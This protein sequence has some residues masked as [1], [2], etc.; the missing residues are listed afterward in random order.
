MDR[1][2]EGMR[3]LREPG[4]GDLVW[5]EECVYSF[6]T[7]ADAGGLY[8]NL[9]TF[10]AVSGEYAAWEFARA[11]REGRVGLYLLQQW[12]TTTKEEPAAASGEAESGG[13]AAAEGG[14]KLTK[15]GIGVEGGAPLA[16][17]PE[18]SK[19]HFVV[20]WDGSGRIE[21]A[22]RVALEDGDLPEMVRRVCEAVLAHDDAARTAHVQSA[23]AWEFQ[24]KESKYAKALPLAED[25]QAAPTDPSAWKCALCELTTP[26]WLNLSTGVVAC[27]RRQPDGSGGRGHALEHFVA[28]GRRYPLCVKLGTIT[29]E[30]GGDVYSYAPDEDDSVLD[31]YLREHLL[32]LGLD[33]AS[34]RK[35]EKT[36]MELTLDA[37][38]KLVLDS[39]TEE[40][41]E[42]VP[43]VARGCVGLVN[44]GNSCYMNSVLQVLLS[45]PEVRA[46]YL[47]PRAL[48]ALQALDPRRIPEDLN[49]QVCKLALAL[50]TDQ[51][52]PAW[53]RGRA[54]LVLDPP[55]D[56]GQEWDRIAVT[57]RVVRTV[58][59][60]GHGEFMT[61]R[62]QDTAE[63]LV[64]VLDRLAAVERGAAADAPADAPATASLFRF[65][66]ETRIQCLESGK[67]RYSDAAA[68]PIWT[69]AIPVEL[70]SNPAEVAES[71]ARQAAWDEERKAAVLAAAHVAG[72]A[73]AEKRARLDAAALTKPPKAVLPQVSWDSVLSTWCDG[74]LI[75]DLFSTA[76]GRNGP[77]QATSRFANFP[78]YLCVQLMRQVLDAS[79]KEVKID[80]M[81][82]MPR[83]LDLEALRAPGGLQPGEELLAE[84]P[85]AA[86]AG[87]RGARGAAPAAFTPDADMLVMLQGMGFSENACK[88][89]LRAVQ[90][91]GLE[92]ASDWLMGHMDDADFNDPLPELAAAAA[93]AAAAHAP[94]FDAEAVSLITAMG[95]SDALAKKALHETQGNAERAADWLMARIDSLDSIDTSLDSGPAAGG[96]GGGAGAAGAAAGGGGA[97]AGAGAGAGGGAEKLDGVGRYHLF[98][99]ISHI[100]SNVSSG[101][102][103][104][105]ILREGRFV[106]FNDR[107]VAFSEEP[108]IPH[109]YLFFYRRNDLAPAPELFGPTEDV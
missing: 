99:V 37:N 8:V 85:A 98:A 61:G 22:P 20:A 29:G 47:A 71:R 31:P 93:S 67:V 101:H 24:A 81:V 72:A 89:A 19:A 80:A 23:L 54:G 1:V 92:Q 48:A 104:A 79:G 77:H 65:A 55:A 36:M 91:A 51:R 86:A 70:A 94:A 97:G 52:L 26:L 11:P 30:G 50:W 15:L 21:E 73:P 58:L 25:A 42:L 105:H 12:T 6:W 46:R 102:Y 75:A 60:K 62:Q 84:P 5:R 40:G 108:P 56:A 28:T 63:Y 78:P 100:G 16:R 14:G 10:C 13:A 4:A 3:G 2:R 88:R 53:A 49:A 107:K 41:K 27:G 33:A 68:Q 109:G 59:A 87:A 39:V 44:T 74:S 82:D 9:R 43:A 95:F 106:L 57:P 45:V 32:R 96:G 69:L 64:H 103:V 90:N 83:L 66:T 35:T 18:V 7:P 38:E 17:E 76:T 34:Q